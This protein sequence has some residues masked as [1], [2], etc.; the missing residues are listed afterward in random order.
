MTNFGCC[1]FYA[2]HPVRWVV[3][4]RFEKY[5]I[6]KY[7]QVLI[8]ILESKWPWRHSINDDDDLVFGRIFLEISNLLPLFPKEVPCIWEWLGQ[9]P[10]VSPLFFL[11]PRDW[12]IWRTWDPSLSELEGKR[13]HPGL[14]CR[15]DKDLGFSNRLLAQLVKNHILYQL[16][17]WF[18]SLKTQ[19]N[20]TKALRVYTVKIFSNFQEK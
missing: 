14:I 13:S 16:P 1:A 12:S 3:E 11:P 15:L 7:L 2:L 17:R 18:R 19:Q 20:K 8:L 6:K 5:V 10:W 4:S 9:T